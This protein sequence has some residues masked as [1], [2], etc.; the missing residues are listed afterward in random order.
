MGWQNS[1]GL[2]HLGTMTV[3]ISPRYRAAY[4]LL[5]TPRGSTGT[6]RGRYT[7][8]VPVCCVMYKIIISINNGAKIKNVFLK[9]KIFGYKLSF[10]KDSPKNTNINSPSLK[11]FSRFPEVPEV[12]EVHYPD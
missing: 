6:Y 4:T 3:A 8:P 11:C 1:S 2:N 9:E 5:R 10:F 12:P 7:E